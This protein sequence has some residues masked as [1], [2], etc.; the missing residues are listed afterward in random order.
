MIGGGAYFI[1]LTVG[2]LMVGLLYSIIAIGFVL[3]YKATGILN[4]AQ[5]EIMLISG[6]TCYTLVVGCNLPVWMAFIGTI[7]ICAIIG[8]VVE[9]IVL[10]PM[11]GEPTFATIMITIGLSIL[12]RSIAG[13]LF[14]HENYVFPSPFSTDPIK[15][16][17][18]A[19]SQVDVLV[20]ICSIILIV[21]FFLFF[22]YSKTGLAM[23]ATA[24]DQGASALMGISVKR[25]FGLTWSVSF[26]TCSIGGFLLINVLALNF[27]ISAVA[28]S[29]FPA[30]VLGGLESIPG[31]V[32]GG[33]IIGL[34][35]N[36]SGG[37]MGQLFTADIKEVMPF[38]CLFVI[39]M[40]KPYGLFGT[41]DIERV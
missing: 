15:F 33:I 30:I 22:K 35:E 1:Q 2:G 38:V 23:R 5:G 27:E 3:I 36:Y 17:I 21:F 32:I 25:I 4:F 16:G 8:L 29:A 14:G 26:A 41:E 31:A 13:I 34:V 18:V 20:I 39:L 37:Y 11:I 9:R 10:R 28:L 19:L 7:F 6:F 24:N 40:I 12:L